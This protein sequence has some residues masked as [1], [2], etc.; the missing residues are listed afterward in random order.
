MDYFKTLN[1]LLCS[2]KTSDSR[3]RIIDN[4][5]AVKTATECMIGLK[6]KNNKIFFIGN[7]GSASI[8]SHMQTDFLRNLRI[9]AVTF[10]D[11]SLLTCMANDH[12]YEYVFEKPIGLLARRGDCLLA[13]SSSGRSP[14]ILNAAGTAKK[15]GCF[16]ITLS[17]FG[18]NN[19]L[20]RLGSINFYI[21]SRAYG[22][23]ELA[24]AAICHCM[25]DAILQKNRDGQI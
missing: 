10:G 7:G 3:G 4:E 14:N 9:P 18:N 12:G 11:P 1:D 6:K 2:I 25:V 24:H 5:N 16:V 23:V 20:R 17:G 19:P 8:A 15:K 13:I 21:N 22:F